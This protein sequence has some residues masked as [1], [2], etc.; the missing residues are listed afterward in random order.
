M[1]ES[2]RAAVRP[3]RVAAW[4]SGA[5]QVTEEEPTGWVHVP[6]D[7]RA[8]E[9]HRV[10]NDEAPV[11][12]YGDASWSLAA[13]GVKPGVT[14]DTLHFRSAR[15]ETGIE[16]P[17][18]VIETSR[19]VAYLFVNRRVP[20]ATLARPNT[21]HMLWLSS[22]GV[23]R[24]VGVLRDLLMW[25]RGQGIEALADFTPE[26]L[27][28]Y[29][30]Q[31]M[32]AVPGAWASGR[33]TNILRICDLAPWLPPEDRLVLP[34]WAD[35]R[36]EPSSVKK[37]PGGSGTGVIEQDVLDPALVWAT[38]LVRD[39]A[40]DILAARA[41]V[42]ETLD[43]CRDA[44]TGE[45]DAWMATYFV[46]RGRVLPHDPRAQGRNASQGISFG[47]LSYLSGFTRASLREWIETQERDIAAVD[48][49]CPVREPVRGLGPDGQPWCPAIDWHDLM[50]AGAHSMHTA[51][52]LQVL[53]GSALVL[54]SLGSL[55]RPQEV[56]TLPM[57]CLEEVPAESPGGI[58]GYL[59]NGTRWKGRG[60]VG[61]P[62]S[63][64]TVG[65]VADA[66][67]V[68]Q[69]LGQGQPG[70]DQWLFP[71]TKAFE[72]R[73]GGY[74]GKPWRHTIAA[75][76]LDAFTNYVNS[77]KVQGRLSKPLLIGDDPSPA[78]MRPK[79]FRRTFSRQVAQ[80]PDGDFALAVQLGHVDTALGRD[81]YASYREAGATQAM[82]AETKAAYVQTLM[83]VSEAI[84]TGGVGVSGPSADRLFEAARLAQPLL[85]QFKSGAAL[86]DL[87]KDHD[88]TLVFDNPKQYS[89]CLYV[90]SRAK[91]AGSD[92]EPDRTACDPTCSCIART[93]NQAADLADDI[94]RLRDE[95]ESPLAPV[96]L[97]DRLGRTADAKQVLLDQHEA[98]RRHLPIVEV[99]NGR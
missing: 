10:V 96:P 87:V 6:A 23:R 1:S 2:E 18:E 97:R 49:D 11:P 83:E 17:Q 33:R 66:V 50:P 48:M 16:Y 51:P 78:K 32:A 42:Q 77:S 13:L 28:H 60:L 61:E 45:V 35:G 99:T 31:G 95:A 76:R 43:A 65:V 91:C 56:L 64:A 29:R 5:A 37:D 34:S 24:Q 3:S 41:E 70:P 4:L 30:A 15:T 79:Q 68:L 98:T 62:Y 55:C 92:T 73:G 21:Q 94:Q 72:D 71:A 39:I 59:L 52:L 44:S 80:R 36:R 53:Y 46:D 93:D 38:S 25:G 58:T 47:Y 85:A 86:T 7:A 22:H 20:Q 26:A 40:P 27:D 67:R 88:Q 84:T 81:G 12:L 9:E 90:P 75:S 74:T 14:V 89:L 63:W 19:R 54:L 82:N 8:I 69:V 57:D